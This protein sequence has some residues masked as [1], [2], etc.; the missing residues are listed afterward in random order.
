M[1]CGL[2]YGQD[3]YLNVKGNTRANTIIFAGNLTAYPVAPLEGEVF[4][5]A[6]E[7]NPRYFDGTF[8]NKFG[9]PKTVASRIVAASDSLGT[10]CVA[11]VCSN[12]KA[13]YV[14]DGTGD[15]EEIN[16]AINN[17]PANGGAVY[18]LE[19]TYNISATALPSP[20]ETLLGIVPH[21][22]T[23]IIGTGRGTVLKVVL[24][25]SSVNVINAV[26]TQTTP[27]NGIL[28]SQLMID[29]NNM[30]GSL[31]IGIYFNSVS[32]SK[33]DKVWVEKI[34]GGSS[35]GASIV[36]T[37]SSNN[38]ISNNNVHDNLKGIYLTS[39]SNNIISYNNLQDN[40]YVGGIHL[41]SSSSNNTI[42]NNNIQANNNNTVDAG[43]YL[44]TYCSSNTISSNNIQGNTAQTYNMPMG[45]R[46][47]ASSNNTISNNNIQGISGVGIYV[48]VSSNNTISSNNVQGNTR[49][50]IYLSSSSNNTIIA[51]VVKDNGSE[52]GYYCGIVLDGSSSNI[53][54]SNRVSDTDGLGYGIDILN[55]TCDKNYLIGNLIDEAGYA[56]PI[57]DLGTNTKYTD[58]AKVTLERQ[59]VLSVSNDATITPTGPASYV[60]VVGNGGA[61]IANANTPIAAG[62]AAGD[63]LILEGTDNTNTVTIPDSGVNLEAARALGQYDTLKLIWNGSRWIEIGYVNN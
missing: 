15:Q 59:A 25:A 3:D 49:Q 53:I 43:I 22:N 61:V 8:W 46:F 37:S 42:S 55:D 51:N 13:D 11:G 47:G 17:L 56:K 60:P 26:G 5:N 2:L 57:Q 16:K 30:T 44:E 40:T 41:K 48:S 28:I 14:C 38:T 63:I 31:N 4:Y 32:H 21:S 10:T 19:G 29:G 9:G 20:P 58:K 62:K 52:A 33:I 39:S 7:K 27:L 45:I 24:G 6:Q 18:L 12:P 54:S 36:L 23:A 35:S 34:R 50:G 1:D